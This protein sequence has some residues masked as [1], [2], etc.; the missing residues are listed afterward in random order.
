MTVIDRC[1]PW[2]MADGVGLDQPS[3]L[4]VILAVIVRRQSSQRPRLQAL[5]PAATR[6]PVAVEP[7]AT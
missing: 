7:D 5:S 2:L 1:S 6:P 4:H 3:K